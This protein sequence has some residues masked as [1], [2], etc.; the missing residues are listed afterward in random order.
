MEKNYSLEQFCPCVKEVGFQGTDSWRQRSRRIYDHQLLFCYGKGAN[1]RIAGQLWQLRQGDLA[2][3]KPD[4]P[5]IFWVDGNQPADVLWVH[6]DMEPRNDADWVVRFY[7]TTE[8]Y[9]QL[10]GASMPY[11]THIRPQAL[12]SGKPLPD[13]V[14]LR[15]HE[16]AERLLRELYRAFIRKDPLFA[17]TS[18]ALMLGL[19]SMVLEERQEFQ[20]E[21]RDEWMLS[22]LRHYINTHYFQKVTMQDLAACVH[23]SPDYCGRI[24]RSRTGKTLMEYLSE[25]RI[26]RAR[27]L[28]LEEDLTVA[29][30]GEMVGFKRSNHFSRICRKVTGKTPMALRRHMISLTRQEYIEGAH[31]NVS[32]D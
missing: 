7:N 5:H 25:V 4:T 28:L 18:K 8:M 27:Q 2:I 29:Q 15:R 10:F 6:F 19:F 23:M 32:S 31:D 12:L 26:D 30:V 21:D 14:H 13:V 20:T 16:E 9:A 22:M 3:I 24:F 17:I 1:L 11:P